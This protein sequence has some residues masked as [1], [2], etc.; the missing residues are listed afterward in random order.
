MEVIILHFGINLQSIVLTW[1]EFANY[2]GRRPAQVEV[3]GSKLPYDIF[4]FVYNKGAEHALN[5]DP[6]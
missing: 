5:Y 6:E 2:A 1:D 4:R 3:C